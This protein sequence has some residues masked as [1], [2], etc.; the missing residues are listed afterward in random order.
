MIKA[1]RFHFVILIWL[2]SQFNRLQ[3]EGRH[4]RA[5]VS[6]ANAIRIWR[7]TETPYKERE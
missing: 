3:A 5:S 2:A 4:C 7:F 1:T 6:D